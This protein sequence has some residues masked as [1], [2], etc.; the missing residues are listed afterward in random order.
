L[1]SYIDLVWTIIQKKYTQFW[2]KIALKRGKK[3]NGDKIVIN[4]WKLDRRDGR[5]ISYRITVDG[6]M[7]Y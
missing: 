2:E 7:W 1:I 6:G 4:L 3:I 5:C